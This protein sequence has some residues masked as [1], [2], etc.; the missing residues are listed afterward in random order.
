M[1]TGTD[2]YGGV[3][4]RSCRARVSAVAL[5]D[6]GQELFHGVCAGQ[7]AVGGPGVEVGGVGGAG[8]QPGEHP[9]ESFAGRDV[10]GDHR[11]PRHPGDLERERAHHSRT[12]FARRAVHDRTAV[13]VRHHP[14]GG[15]DRVGPVVEVGQ[16]VPDRSFGL[17]PAVLAG[18]PGQHRVDVDPRP[19]GPAGR[20]GRFGRAV[21]LDVGEH[22]AL[23]EQRQ[24]VDA[25]LGDPSERTGPFE[26][27][28][29]SAAQIDDVR[30][31]QAGD[32]PVDVAGGQVLQV[33][34]AQHPP[35]PGRPAVVGGQ[36]AEVA[37][38]D[39]SVEIDPPH[40]STLTARRGRPGRPVARPS[41]VA[42][43]RPAMWKPQPS[44][45]Y[46]MTRN[47]ACASASSSSG[48]ESATMPQP[49]NRRARG[50]SISAQRNAM[51]HSPSPRAS[52]QPTGP[53]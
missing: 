44:R 4:R 39:G 29:R 10:V 19:A 24:V 42:S 40:A 45:A 18:L 49:A 52:T 33:V 28:L 2:R 8:P 14:Q 6:R 13:L 5:I 26:R 3:T 16:V 51:P 20:A 7:V 34:R 38:V 21:G 50:P 12:V 36:P 48:T 25:H 53:A 31:A 30:H 27:D 23:G 11:L 35:G 32:E 1:A 9:F 43:S 15:D 22:A 17:R 41:S 37:D 46:C 47:L